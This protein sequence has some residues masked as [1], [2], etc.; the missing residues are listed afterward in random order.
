M[1]QKEMLVELLKEALPENPLR[2][3]NCTCKFPSYEKI[4]E[5]MLDR[6]VVLPFRIGETVYA[7]DAVNVFDDSVPGNSRAEYVIGGIYRHFKGNL[8]KLLLVATDTETGKETAVYESLKDGK[9]WCRSM[10]MFFSPVDREKYPY[11]TQELRFELLFL[12]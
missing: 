2:G 4:A 7:V 1:K 10:D 3:N 11:A 12:E 8:Y 5:R 9:L 6:I